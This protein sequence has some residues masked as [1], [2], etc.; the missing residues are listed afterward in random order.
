MTHIAAEQM[1]P[2]DYLFDSKIEGMSV[3]LIMTYHLRKI[4]KNIIYSPRSNR[5]KEILFLQCD[6]RC[7]RQVG[8]V[9]AELTRQGHDPSSRMWAHMPLAHCIIHVI[10]KGPS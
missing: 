6:S 7:R 8:S 4:N 5:K 9:F 1:G 2:L 3:I 10:R